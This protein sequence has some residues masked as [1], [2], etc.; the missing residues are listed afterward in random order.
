MSKGLKFL[1][2]VAGI[3]ITDVIILAPG[4]LGVQ[5]GGDSP[6]QTAI[7]VSAL[8]ASALGLSFGIHKIFFKPF[9]A[10][11]LKA[12]KTQED[13]VIALS[14]YKESKVLRNDITF[15]LQQV[16]RMK[17]KKETLLNVLNERFE[18]TELT[19]QKFTSVVIEV[20]KLFYLNLRN[21]LNKVSIFDES[22]YKSIIEKD[23]SRF[24]RQILQEK[25]DLY[26]EYLT[27]MKN[28]ININEEILLDLDKLLMEI[29]RLDNFD[30]IENMS[31]MKEI[32][33]LIEQTKYYKH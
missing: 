11:P 26:N 20:E 10:K 14:Q 19:H 23:T 21:I 30:D 8:T 2:L 22:E 4:L 6:L 12:L 29:S 25:T 24:S 17:K 5:I 31:A 18:P 16:E 33:A 27:F 7:G 32:D 15:A 9:E 3:T 1:G 28:A 13:Y